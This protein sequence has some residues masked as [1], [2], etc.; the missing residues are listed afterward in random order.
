M[1][2]LDDLIWSL[3]ASVFFSPQTLEWVCGCVSGMVVGGC[4]DSSA[5]RQ[6]LWVQ[7]PLYRGPP[8]IRGLP[9]ANG[10]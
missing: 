1:S 4:L 10:T 7:F 5:V 6:A 9:G 8:L 3:S 2:L